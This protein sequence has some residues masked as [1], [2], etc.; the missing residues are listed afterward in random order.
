MNLLFCG[1]G[2]LPMID[3]LRERLPA[4]VSVQGHDRTRPLI[5]QVANVDII[6]PSNARI[7]APVIE[8]AKNLRAILQ[9]AV[10]TEGI[11]M[12]AAKAR[13]IPVCNA[14]GFNS[15]AVAQLALLLILAVAR[16]CREAERTF[17][18]V[19]IGVPLGNEVNGKVLG[20]IGM[21]KAGSK[22]A[23]VAEALQMEV[24]G[25]RSSS[26]RADLE[27]LLRRSDFVSIHTPLNATTRGLIGEAEL[28][29][30]KP[31][32]FLVNCSRGGLIQRPALEAAL[33]SK[34]L[35]GVGLD[36]FWEEPWNPSDP[37]FAREDVVV[38]PHLGGST[39][40]VFDRV[41]DLTV[42]NVRRLTAGEPLLQRIV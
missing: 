11:D 19:R 18:E 28:A 29:L 23:R 35:G 22:L 24:V 12:A 15:D 8:A 5:D 25:V 34:H 20:I 41:A 3:K 9:P 4:G 40:E 6:L 7:D 37:L 32:A 39:L 1:T 26:S 17:R 27:D 31:G 16:R 38:L 42:E 33:E 36:V 14:P 10:G 2:W 13:G 21:G 30:M